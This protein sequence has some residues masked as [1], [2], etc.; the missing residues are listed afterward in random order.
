MSYS[1]RFDADSYIADFRRYV[2][3]FFL[4]P[5]GQKPTAWKPYYDFASYLATQTIFCFTTVPFVILTLPNSML[6]W[7]RVYFYAIIA[8]GASM[9]F[10]ASPAKAQLISR[11]K[12]REGGGRGPLPRTPSYDATPQPILG[13]PN[14]PAREFDEAVQEIREEIEQRRRKGSIVGMPEGKALQAQVI[15][16]LREQPQKEK[17]H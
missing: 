1:A 10:F 13:L 9:A 7:S 2:R 5:D 14:D 17:E 16:K 11:L 15:N 4:T 8:V 6:V 3:P 12:A